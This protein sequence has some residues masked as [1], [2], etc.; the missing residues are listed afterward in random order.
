MSVQY[1]VT[2]ATSG[3]GGSVLKT[4][5]AHVDSSTVVA[6]SSN[7]EVESQ[8]T[9]K[10]IQFRQANYDDSES[11]KKAFRGVVKLFFVSSPERNNEKRSKQHENVINA[12]KEASVGHVRGNLIISHSS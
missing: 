5:L 3:L 9:E 12:A 1:F 8:F 6:S 10:G 11:L 7:A 4:L 2:G